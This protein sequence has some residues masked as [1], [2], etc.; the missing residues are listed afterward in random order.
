MKQGTKIEK[1]RKKYR[2]RQRNVEPV[3]GIIKEVMS[4]RQFLLRMLR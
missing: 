4:F 2:M 3:F 1:G